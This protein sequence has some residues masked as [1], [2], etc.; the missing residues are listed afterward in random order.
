MFIEIS[1]KGGMIGSKVHGR[2]NELN[3]L[4]LTW[5]GSSA[6][7]QNKFLHSLIFFIISFLRIALSFAKRQM[8]TEEELKNENIAE[9]H[10]MVKKCEGEGRRMDGK[11]KL[12]NFQRGSLTGKWQGTK[13]N[14]SDGFEVP[15][16]GNFSSH[17]FL[18]FLLVVV[19]VVAAY[20]KERE[21]E[22]F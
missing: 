15:S 4:K 14:G 12:I 11:S 19:V 2:I 5:H 21:R 9:G 1:T 13:R 6:R 16:M 18:L 22:F 8:M 10:Y 20:V 3:L 17:F 7:E